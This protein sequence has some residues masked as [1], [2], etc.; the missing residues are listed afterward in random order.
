LA[1]YYS[2]IGEALYVVKVNLV[3]AIATRSHRF[4]VGFM[5]KGQGYSRKRI[6]TR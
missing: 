3:F 4:P 6:K 5:G 2:N 1:E